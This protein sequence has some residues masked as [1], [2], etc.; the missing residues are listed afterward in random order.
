MIFLFNFQGPEQIHVSKFYKESKNGQFVSY[1]SEDA[2]TLYQ[3]FRKGAYE[4]NNGPCLG[5]RDS[6]TSPYVVRKKMFPIF[7]GDS[8]IRIVIANSSK[9]TFFLA[10]DSF[11]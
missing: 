8:F 7:L 10:V 4:S 1:I 5:Y 3:T 11:Q 9:F 6:L 2:Q